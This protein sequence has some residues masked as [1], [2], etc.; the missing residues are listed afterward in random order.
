MSTVGRR[1]YVDAC[2]NLTNAAFAS[3]LGAIL[4]RATEAGLVGLVMPASSLDDD[5]RSLKARIEDSHDLWV[6][7]PL[8]VHPWCVEELH[9]TDEM[10]SLLAAL[11]PSWVGEIGLDYSPACPVPHQLQ[12]AAFSRQLDYALAR[13][14]PVYLHCRDAFDDMLPLLEDAAGR[15]GEPLAGIL[16][17]FTG[18]AS[19]AS[20]IIDLGL[21]LGVTGHIL[22]AKGKKGRVFREILA[23]SVPL[24]RVVVETDAPYL[25]PRFKGLASTAESYGSPNRNEPS[26]VVD[27]A[28]ALAPVY[29]V[30]PDDIASI[31][32]QTSTRLFHPPPDQSPPS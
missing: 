31:T 19:Q 10:E 16:H 24:D 5:V 25:L 8:G 32:T 7:T 29:G 21:H 28:N 17:C 23:G 4:T 26:F 27:I 2:A 18:N 30:S 13:N 3:D 15:N 12:R 6:A 11:S 20:A 14:L 22:A 9:G 1:R